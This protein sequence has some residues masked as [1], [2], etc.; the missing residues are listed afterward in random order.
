M[1]PGSGHE[2]P[3]GDTS[4]ARGRWP[5]LRLLRVHHW[6]KNL[7][8]GVPYLTAGAWRTPGAGGT[9]A[10]AGLA[11]SLLAS[12]SYVLN[13]LA[14]LAFDRAHAVKRHRPLASGAVGRPAALAAALLLGALGFWLAARVGG[15][16]LAAL[17]GYVL[18]TTAYTRVLKRIALLDVL[19]LGALWTLRLVAGAAAIGVELSA[20]LLSFGAFLF[21]SLALVKRVAELRASTGEA[22]T[23]LPGRGYCRADLPV[24][25]AF[26]VA[27]G[28]MS[29]VVLAL[30]VDSSAA[31]LRYPHHARLWLVCPAIWFWLGRLWLMTG[32]GAMNED[33]LV[34]SLRDPAS[35]CALAAV[36]VVWLAALGVL[37]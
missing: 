9:L 35:W 36:A 6:L 8:L 29:V 37:G 23:L 10:L 20:W 33:P 19:A 34:Y 32:R 3:G 1:T 4:A 13:D 2:A 16:F 31:E 22:A 12:A 14:D 24:L 5:W 25:A 15:R 17:L 21:Q 27:T 7:L 18:L 28:V 26:G 30:F 11:F